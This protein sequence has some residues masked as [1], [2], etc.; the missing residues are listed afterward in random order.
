MSSAATSYQPVQ[1]LESTRLLYDLLYTPAEYEN[2]LERYSSGLIFRLGFGKTIKTGDEELVRRIMHV[3]HTVERVASPGAYLVDTFP[4]LMCLPT[5]LA[6]FKQELGRLHKEELGL[7]RQLQDDVRQEMKD[8]K[9]PQCW[10]RTFLENQAEY[11]LSP[12][13]GAYVVGTLFEA[14]AGT[15][16]AAMMSFL[17]AMV[18]HPA[19]Q[20][21]LQ[22]EIDVVVG[23][24]SMPDFNHMPYLPTVRAVVKETLRWRPVTAGGVPHQLVKDD[25]YNGLFLPA[26]TNIHA[27]QWAINR[28]PHLYPDPETFNPARWLEPQYPTYR[29]PLTTYPTIQNFSAFGFGRR[30]CPGMNIAERSL[31]LLV[32]RVA[33]TFNIS[34]ARDERGREIAVPLYDYTSGFNVQP[35]PFAFDMKARSEDKA[36]MVERAMREAE[37]GDPLAGR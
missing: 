10:E 15:T 8:G 14:G 12:D 34:K 37:T 6:P 31:N 36:R 22:H 25:V 28:D 18:H 16:A 2:H 20:A 26:G 11:G 19:W 27:N 33:W 35:K 7:F 24:Q 5:W 17:L 30:I 4:I 21:R 23:Q 3:V 9:A 29:E 32:A 1:V 13:E